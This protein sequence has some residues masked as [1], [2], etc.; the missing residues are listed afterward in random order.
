VIKVSVLYPYSPDVRFDH[1][2]YR[3]HHLPMVKEYMGERLLRYSI[4]RG[5]GG[6]AP[7]EPPVYIAACHLYC[8]SVESFQAAMQPHAEIVKG[9]IKYYTDLE[10]LIQISEVVVE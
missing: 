1:D 3:D 9:D 6:A 10:P 2:Y 4:E 8:D 5:L 7:N